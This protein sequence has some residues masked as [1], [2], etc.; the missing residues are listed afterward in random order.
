MS[1]HTGDLRT[2]CHFLLLYRD[3]L[4]FYVPAWSLVIRDGSA[5]IPHPNTIALKHKPV[6]WLLYNTWRVELADQV[7]R[8]KN[9]VDFVQ[10]TLPNHRIVFMANTYREAI[11]LRQVRV[12]VLF[13]PHNQFISPDAFYPTTAITGREF[14]AVYH[15][16]FEPYK[17]HELLRGIPN[18]LLVGRAYT[19]DFGQQL[20]QIIP[21]TRIVNDTLP[22]NTWLSPAEVNA[23]YNRANVGLALSK[24]EGAML[25]SMEYM[26]A[27]LPVVTTLNNGGRDY[28]LDGRF[29]LHVPDDPAEIKTAIDTFVTQQISPEFIRIETLRKLYQSRLDF[30]QNLAKMLDICPDNVLENI[31]AQSDRKQLF[32]LIS[33]VKFVEEFA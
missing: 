11:E 27:G 22:P 7:Q 15:G 29:T 28:Y 8:A 2:D 1:D 19:R 30:A 5:L 17:R 33:T 32:T 3:P 10:T 13:A 9:L 4:V 16:A 20:R 26:L 12:P 14:D 24:E 21:D 25:V 31:S 18:L 23:C 6:T